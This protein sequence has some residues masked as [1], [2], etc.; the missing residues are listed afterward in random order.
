MTDYRDLLVRYIAHVRKIEKG[1]DLLG[2][3][4][5]AA[6]A[7][8]EI[9][10]LRRLGDARSVNP[11]QLLPEKIGGTTPGDRPAGGWFSENREA[12]ASWK[13]DGR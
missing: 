11:M 10:E 1:N 4:Y 7:P 6:F 12:E 2:D 13:A 3:G 9:R 5:L 8:D